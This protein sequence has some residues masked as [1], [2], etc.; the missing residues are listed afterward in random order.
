MLNSQEMSDSAAE[1]EMDF[2]NSTSPITNKKESGVICESQSPN[3]KKNKTKRIMIMCI[4][5][6]IGGITCGI[7]GVVYFEKAKQLSVSGE[8]DKKT[9][10]DTEESGKPASR[11]E[12][13]LSQEVQSSG[14]ISIL[15]D[16]NILITESRRNTIAVLYDSINLNQI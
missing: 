9:G 3:A 1:R 4:L 6:A 2:M 5:L 13:A 11:E 14:K 15:F 7:V 8:Q 12:C 10:P 16:Q